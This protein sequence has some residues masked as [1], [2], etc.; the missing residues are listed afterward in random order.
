MSIQ[1]IHNLSMIFSN[2][3]NKCILLRVSTRIKRLKRTKL[4]ESNSFRTK[5]NS[6]WMRII[7]HH[8][9][10]T[11]ATNCENNYLAFIWRSIQRWLYTVYGNAPSFCAIYLTLSLI[12]QYGR[13]KSSLNVRKKGES[14]YKRSSQ[15]SKWRG[16]QMRGSI[17][18]LCKR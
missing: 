7:G 4:K 12:S 10:R 8:S 2:I 5:R 16:Y 9:M 17:Q 11:K 14:V 3:E 18:S 13:N 15:W 6:I 1:L